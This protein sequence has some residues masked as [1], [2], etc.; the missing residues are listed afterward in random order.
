M[1]AGKGDTYRKVIRSKFDANFDS[2]TWGRCIE[3]TN[4]TKVTLK[5]RANDRPRVS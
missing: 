4:K 5:R 2:I 1:S 3:D